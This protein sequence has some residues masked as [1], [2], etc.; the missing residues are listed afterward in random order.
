MFLSIVNIN[1]ETGNKYYPPLILRSTRTLQA[2]KQILIANTFCV[3]YHQR[4]WKINATCKFPL[5]NKSIV[6]VRKQNTKCKRE[7]DG[8]IIQLLVF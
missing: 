2:E 3:A 1:W 6:A 5:E 4:K 7:L 8:K